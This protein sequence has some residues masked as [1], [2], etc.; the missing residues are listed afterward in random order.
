[1]NRQGA[2]LVRERENWQ[3]GGA[4]K[5]IP[6]MVYLFICL[7]GKYIISSACLKWLSFFE[8]SMRPKLLFRVTPLFDFLKYGKWN[9]N[10]NSTNP[11]DFCIQ[12][13]QDWNSGAPR[14]MERTGRVG[15]MLHPM[16]R[17]ALRTLR[18]KKREER[19]SC[20][21]VNFVEGSSLFPKEFWTSWTKGTL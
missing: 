6:V 7:V 17:C 5:I 3:L 10:W 2:L 12:Q 18:E 1:M 11:C 14:E 20:Y 4:H 19:N 16:M 9:Q 21:F 8:D 15:T 13:P